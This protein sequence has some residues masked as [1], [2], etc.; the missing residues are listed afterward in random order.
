M[1][2]ASSLLMG[3]LADGQGFSLKERIGRWPGLLLS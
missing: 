1:A 2:R 3:G